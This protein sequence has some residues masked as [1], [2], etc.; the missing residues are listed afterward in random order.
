MTELPKGWAR[1]AIEDLLEPLSDGRLI[2]QGW[3]PQCERQP[4][5]DV[6]TWGV[7]KTTAI[8]PG[9]FLED[10]NK[11]LP[12]S[13]EPRP[14]L[15]VRAGDLLL[16]CA[17]PRARC[18]IACLVREARPLL[19]L[20]GK[21]YRFRVSEEQ[22]DPRYVEYGLLSPDVV[23][24][25]D[26][27]KT[28]ISESGLNLTHPRFRALRFPL[29]P[30]A[31]QER[32]VVAIAEAFSQLDAGEA[33]LRTVRR[34]LE[35]MRD[36][37]LA[38]AVTGRLVPQ[39]PTDTPATKLLADLGVEPVIDERAPAAWAAAR[40]EELANLITD[41]DHRPPKRVPS[42]IPHLTAKNVRGGR[43]DLTG[44]SFVDDAGFA[45]TRSRYEPIAG[46]V[47]VTC[48]GTIGRVAVVPEG[49]T[50]SA[51]RNL[52]AVRLKPAIEPHFAELALGSPAIQ[53]WM[54]EASGSTAQPHLYLRDLRSIVV[55]VAPVEEQQRIVSEVERQFS[56]L[57]A[58]ERAVE[59]GLARSAALRRSVLKAAFEGRLVP[60]DPSDEPASVLLGRIRA[61]RPAAPKPARRSRRT[62]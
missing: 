44:C 61:E 6:L 28:G 52:A 3:S 48:V 58:C 18:G 17:G 53:N 45:Q 60:Q 19:M 16:T 55:P 59:A 21:M 12:D 41:G 5:G 34:L 46:D 42:G 8:Q 51:D 56:F 38:A 2:H 25:I 36:A 4:A 57:E 31:E 62:A 9:E 24:A 37:V 30:R 1:P 27:I 49:L 33:G 15:E 26:E 54:A 47:I 50:F 11:R 14:G 39:D 7:L 35:R 23:Q 20:S 22:I 10:E 13:L 43:F 40:L 32:I 29:A